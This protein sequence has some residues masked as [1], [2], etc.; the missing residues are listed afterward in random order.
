[1]FGKVNIVTRGDLIM[2]K[3]LMEHYEKSAAS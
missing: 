3:R 2:N 1:M